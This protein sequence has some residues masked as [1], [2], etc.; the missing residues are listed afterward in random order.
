MAAADAIHQSACVTLVVVNL[1]AGKVVQEKFLH[2]GKAVDGM[3][4]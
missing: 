3:G 4:G 2:T 1:T